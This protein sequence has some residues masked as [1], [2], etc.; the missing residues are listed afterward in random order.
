MSTGEVTSYQVSSD[1]HTTFV[2]LLLHYQDYMFTVTANN[3]AGASPASTPWTHSHRPS[4]R[5]APTELVLVTSTSM[6]VTWESPDPAE[7][8]DYVGFKVREPRHATG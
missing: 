4:D 8:V 2:G 1:Q 7:G 5:R 6:R 3:A